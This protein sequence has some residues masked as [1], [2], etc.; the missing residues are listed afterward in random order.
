MINRLFATLFFVS[1]L[2]LVS[3]ISGC[4]NEKASMSNSVTINNNTFTVDIADDSEERA[5]GLMSVESMEDSKGMLFV[6]SDEAIRGFWMKDTLIPLDMIFIDS[7]LSI[8]DINKG[9][10]PCGNEACQVYYSKSPAR[11]ILEING[12]L[13]N[14]LNISV[15][16]KVQ[17]YL[18][19]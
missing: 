2:L 7:N 3:G 1:A 15:G 18:Q 19:P 5:R 13:S 10:Q 6:Y 4:Y 14:R 8:T 9:A 16:D 11:Y 12:G 17:I